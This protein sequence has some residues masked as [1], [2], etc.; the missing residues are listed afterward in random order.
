MAATEPFVEPDETL[1]G[2]TGIEYDDDDHNDS[3]SLGTASSTGSLASTVLDYSY[4]NGR[5]YHAFRS[6]NYVLPN[7]EAEQDRLDLTHHLFAMLL[8]G[9]LHRAPV[10]EPKRVLDLGTGTSIWPITFADE[11]PTTE[12]IATDLSPIQPKWAPP[13]LT[14]QVDDIETEWTFDK[15]F[16]FIH[17]RIL[18]GS[19]SDW[20]RLLKTAYA[21]L[22][23]GGY[24]EVVEWETWSFTD[25]DSLPQNSRFDHWQ[26]ELNKAAATFG[27]EMRIAPKIKAWVEE[28]GFEGVEQEIVKV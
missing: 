9:E 26:K 7:D 27:R 22:T 6:G 3:A 13:N 14:F 21:N 1:K 16:D 8:G 20:P 19:I 25:D 24:I 10:K 28:A 17:I 5:R 12:I 4:E 18:G 11:H 2:K 15:P 23:P